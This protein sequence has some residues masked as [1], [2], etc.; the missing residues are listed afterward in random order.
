MELNTAKMLHDLN[1]SCE[2]SES[3]VLTKVAAIEKRT[4]TILDEMQ[5]EAVVQ[6]AGHGLMVLTGGPGTGKT[7]TINTLISYF[8]SEGLSV[9]LGAPTG[10]AA[11]RMTE[12]TGCEAKTLHRLLEISAVPEN[13]ADRGSFARN[14]ENPLEADVVIIDE[15][16]M[17]DIYLMHSLLLAIV[18]GTR[19]IMVGDRNQLPSVGPGSVLKDIIE[20]KCFPVVRLSRIFRQATE[21]DIVMNAHKINRGEHVTLD[22]KS[23]DFFFLKKGRC[24]RDHQRGADSDPKEAAEVCPRNT[25][26]YP[27]AHTHAKRSSGSGALK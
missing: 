1:I 9:M 6:A 25:D 27:G 21:S 4:G 19:L 13:G 24:Q 18:P 7:T 12:A 10:R 20:S 3:A 15:M 8:E 16:S 23:R 11:K 26:R 22:N 5:K 2:I 14:Q 17:V